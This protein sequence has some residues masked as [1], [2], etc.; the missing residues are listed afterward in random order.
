MSFTFP[1]NSHSYFDWSCKDC[2]NMRQ[3]CLYEE[4]KSECVWCKYCEKD[5]SAYSYK[6]HRG[7][8]THLLLRKR[9]K[10]RE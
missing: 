5:V 6:K 10:E 9:Y 2:K 8:R 3:K 7:T 1:C 4:I